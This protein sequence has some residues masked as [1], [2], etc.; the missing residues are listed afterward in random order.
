MVR[1]GAVVAGTGVIPSFGR[2][3]LGEDDLQK[4]AVQVMGQKVPMFTEH[5]FDQPIE[6]A[7]VLAEVRD[8]PGED[9]KHLYV[10]YDVPEEHAHTN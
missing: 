7:V 8:G 6:V 3:V 9:E 2:S 10:E 1:V 4:L 5:D